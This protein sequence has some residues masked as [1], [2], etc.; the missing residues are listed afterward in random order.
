MLQIVSLLTSKFTDFTQFYVVFLSEKNPYQH[1][2][3]FCADVSPNRNLFKTGP[4]S[5]KLL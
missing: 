1:H 3:Q 2:H 5:C 4:S